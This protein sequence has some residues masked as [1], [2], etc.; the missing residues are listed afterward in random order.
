M[1]SEK[2]ND[3]VWALIV[4]TRAPYCEICGE[5]MGIE[6]HHVFF[7]SQVDF[8]IRFNTMFGISLCPH[9]HRAAPYAPHVNINLFFEELGRRFK[10]AQPERYSIIMA[11][12]ETPVEP[13]PL[14]P[15]YD[16]IFKQLQT[17]FKEVESRAWM[18]S[19][20]EP[21]F[22]MNTVRAPKYNF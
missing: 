8:E 20:I 11:M 17:E 1:K 18:E 2:D 13:N 3:I 15:N 21:S 7:K 4:K 16:E 9:C 19:D 12:R 14:S 10:N 6:A 5:T 22:G